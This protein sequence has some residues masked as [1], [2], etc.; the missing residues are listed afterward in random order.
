M[1]AE[2]K[3]KAIDNVDAGHRTAADVEL[4]MNVFQNAVSYCWS[5]DGLYEQES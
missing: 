2:L 4:L 1:I 5:L 3:Q